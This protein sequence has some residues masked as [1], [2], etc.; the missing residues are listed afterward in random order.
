M[1]DRLPIDP[2]ADARW[3]RIERSLFKKVREGA[4]APG[5]SPGSAQI[6]SRARL[7]RAMTVAA[8]IAGSGAAAAALVMAIRPESRTTAPA[9]TSRIV[10]EASPSHV[11]FGEAALDVAPASIVEV[12]DEP[13]RTVV[14]LERGEIALRVAPRPADRPLVVEAGDVRIRVVGTEFSVKREAEG[15]T[16]RVVRGVVEVRAHGERAEVAAGERWP[17][18]GAGAGAQAAEAMPPVVT[19][20][21]PLPV[22][23][24]ATSGPRSAD[25]QGRGAREGLPHPAGGPGAASAQAQFEA[26]ASLEKRD[27]D[28]ALG[29]Y[30]A[31]A[32]GSDGWAA[33]ALYA[34]GRLEADR[35]ERSDAQRLLAE[36][37]RRFP[38]GP[39]AQDARALLEA[40]R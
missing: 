37:L 40:L 8:A 15:A 13:R 22:A 31:L 34:A 12:E 2:M 19:F 30:A 17:A 33:N 25:T 9:P 1:S 16:V 23:P 6:A 21:P 20:V 10:T 36:Y 3:A 35:H 39:N 7:V 38:D 28:A 29:R 24:P 32:R 11:V 5:A 4:A 26:A 18:R 27:P 14:R